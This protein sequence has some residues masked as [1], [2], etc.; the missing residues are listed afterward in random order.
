[1]KTQQLGGYHC[2]P[3]WD[4]SGANH[5]AVVG[6]K[7][8][9]TVGKVGG[10]LGTAEPVSG[11]LQSRLPFS[12]SRVS[13]WQPCGGSSPKGR[14]KP[15]V[16]KQSQAPKERGQVEKHVQSLEEQP[17]FSKHLL[18]AYYILS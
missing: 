18:S 13:C 6:L 1:M 16:E 12:Q 8:V 2:I 10:E 4:S 3:P 11:Q 9:S 17:F 5:T 14:I 7:P 15:R